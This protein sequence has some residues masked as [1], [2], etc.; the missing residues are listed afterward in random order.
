MIAPPSLALQLVMIVVAAVTR[1]SSAPMSAR[2][3]N[4]T[5][6]SIIGDRG[7]RW[8]SSKD[9]VGPRMQFLSRNL[10]AKAGPAEMSVLP[11]D[12]DT[13]RPPPPL[14]GTWPGR[15]E[16]KRI[17][18][19]DCCRACLA[20]WWCRAWT[21][22]LAGV[23][24]LKDN[25]L[26]SRR[27]GNATL[28]S[29]GVRRY[30]PAQVLPSPRYA[31]CVVN[32]SQTITHGENAARAPADL[33]EEWFSVVKEKSLAA[34]CE[35]KQDSP[36]ASSSYHWSVMTTNGN[37]WANLGADAECLP[38][39]YHST[40]PQRPAGWPP[41]VNASASLC[42][43][44][45]GVQAK[46]P[47][48]AGA[49]GAG[50]VSLKSNDSGSA[51]RFSYFSNSPLGRTFSGNPMNQ[52]K[53]LVELTQPD[54]P[55]LR[56]SFNWTFEYDANL[57]VPEHDFPSNQSWG[58]A[59]W[60]RDNETGIGHVRLY[61]QTSLMYPWY[62]SFIHSIVSCKLKDTAVIISVL[63]RPRADDNPVSRPC[64]CQSRHSFHA[65]CVH[66]Q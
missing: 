31:N 10:C 3:E 1:C 20:E 8:G 28:A 37:G 27:V 4:V 45:G 26:P 29:A 47:V 32:G 30:M 41:A 36:G 14:A 42:P 23:C 11:S 2:T 55:Y 25:A 56:G 12:N 51:Q 60:W 34:R 52:P 5:Y 65:D 9:E 43:N 58:K 33:D 66:F 15:G 35:K 64:T 6:R 18:A 53:V 59:E 16:V 44:T 48:A 39:C 38:Q 22:P 7:M 46:S 63:A 40:D 21:E 19:S 54:D 24:S 17:N 57:A 50:A 49:G 61:S 62:A 13:C